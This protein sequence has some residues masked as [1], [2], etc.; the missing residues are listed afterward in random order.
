VSGADTR[1]HARVGRTGRR[2]AL[3]L[4][5]ALVAAA[6]NLSCSSTAPVS[7]PVPWL[8]LNYNSGSN[9]GP[10]DQFS[11]LG[12]PYDREGALE[13]SAAQTPSNTVSLARGL[14][15]ALRAEMVP[16]VVIN[17]A[18][19]RSGCTGDPNGSTL[20]LPNDRAEV[21]G[22]VRDAVET[23]AAIRRFEPGR[24]VLFEPMNEPWSWASPPGTPSGRVAAVEYAAILA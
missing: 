16:D 8:G 10:V 18:G 2:R 21:K 4:L 24:R 12:I 9:T 19:G 6:A 1:V 20:C 11:V 5:A 14:R 3:G 13:L 22:Y 7:S 23:M 17:P 15:T